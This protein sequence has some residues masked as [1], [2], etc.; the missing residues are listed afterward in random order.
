MKRLVGWVVAVVALVVVAV[1]ADRVT[2]RAAENGAVTAFEQ[3]ADDV[4]GAQIDIRGFPFLTQLVAGELD[5]VTGS[6]DTASFGGYAVSDVQVDARGVGTSEPYTIASGTASGVIAASS[7]QDVVREQSGLD[8]E[9]ATDGDVLA[10]GTAVLGLDLTVDVVPR[11]AGPGTLAVDV[12]AVRTPV[13]VVSVD[14]LPSGIAGALGGLRVPLD[15]PEGVA[16][17]SVAV[18]EDGVRVGVSGTDVAAGSLVAS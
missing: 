13:G 5:H 2:V 3:Q 12:Q 4:A 15:L 8:V 6:A 1:V 16:L 14:D 18:A 10:V 9:L 17:E 7:L 11:V